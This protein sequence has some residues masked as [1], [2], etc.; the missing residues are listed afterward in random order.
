MDNPTAGP[1]EFAELLRRLRTSAALS[2]E[3]LAERAGLTAKAIGALERGER[4]RPYPHTVRSLADALDLD[5]GE[6][7]TLNV[8]ARPR[9]IAEAAPKPTERAE[10]GD[11]PSATP[12]PTSLLG[13]DDDVDDIVRLLRS[14]PARLVT[15]TGPGGVGK[16]A[17]ARAVAVRY[18]ASVTGDVVFIELAPV[19]EA[20]LV[21]P[22]IARALG[23]SQRREP[24]A[25]GIAAAVGDRR[26]LLVLDNLEQVLDAAPAIADLLTHSPGL[27]LLATSRA[28]L[29]V[30]AELERPVGPLS[31][32]TDDDPE[33][34]VASAS[35]AA[36]L[37]RARASGAPL[38]LTDRTAADVAAI[39][40]R[41]DGLPLALELAAVHARFLSL[42]E[43][44][45][46]LDAVVDSPHSRDRP[47]RQ[48]TLQ[49][50]LDWSHDL[51]TADEQRLFARLSVF[52]GGF[53]VAA[54]E[55]LSG[56]DVLGPL[57]GLVDQSLVSFDGLRYRLLEPVRRYA[58][59]R[60]EA[61]GETALAAESASKFFADLARA[62]RAGLR[63]AHQGEW[64]DVLQ[65]DHANLAA[66][67]AWLLESGDPVVAGRAADVAA[68]VWLYW[69]LRGSALEG[70]DWLRRIRD[71][72]L[73]DSA[74]AA[75][76]IA[77]A[78]LL[79]ATGDV[80]AARDP[81]AVA[82][83]AAASAGPERQAEALVLS[84][85]GAVARGEDAHGT[86]TEAIAVASGA[87]DAWASAHAY[88]ALGQHL[89]R[90]GEIASAADAFD[91][92]VTAARTAG[93]AFA[94]ATAL[95]GQA[96]LAQ[97]GGDEGAALPRLVEAI[98]LALDIRTTWTLAFALPLV[99]KAA[100]RHD[101]GAELAVELYAAAAEAA[102]ATIAYPPDS[103]VGRTGI[104]GLREE[105]GD[106][107][108]QQ[109]WDR[110]RNM[111]PDQIRAHVAS[112][113]NLAGPA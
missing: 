17:L 56:G 62:G 107:G 92:A 100:A 2:Q 24:V 113:V 26:L 103:D 75:A 32:P 104:T 66:T 86:A 83:V 65:A 16:T 79:Y 72:T 98:S 54:A 46:R 88:A 91:Q 9:A 6:R 7:L 97:A 93:N 37:D 47:D 68:D 61:S 76:G 50:T 52:A 81:A 71:E 44:L 102:S 22:A 51:L 27:T 42:H 38:V 35:G 60:L 4:R 21:L 82:V 15:L 73:D 23:L 25:S 8:A 39:C 48:R 40:R 28:A 20:S 55:N 5:E 74:R 45:V 70:L 63:G 111:S 3:E 33:S 41:L 108:F 64:L 87:G 99:A 67:I 36:F 112:V 84:A 110:G 13:R 109:A 53:D 18:A 1:G 11:V 80:A 57:A 89:L 49:A 30:L 34:V 14:G 69:A 19:R 105:L 10:P 96:V 29:R 90:A 77:R 78:G 43:L 101:G 95:N 106:E 31:V 12:V 58:A 59:V 94:L 85:L